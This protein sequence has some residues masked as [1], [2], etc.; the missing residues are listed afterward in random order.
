MPSGHHRKVRLRRHHRAVTIRIDDFTRAPADCIPRSIR[1]MRWL[2]AGIVLLGLSVIPALAMPRSVASSAGSFFA[3]AA[4]C[5]TLNLI[6]PGQTEALIK[7]LNNYLSPTD[8]IHMQNGYARGLKESMV[9][10][11]EL[12]RWAPFSADSSSC[13]RVQGVLDDY[14][15]QLEG[16]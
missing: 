9:Y 13:Y 3:A 4:Q 6:T 1:V 2:A 10:V 12:K 8:L 15:A 11:V 16:N 7:A 14:K 5:E